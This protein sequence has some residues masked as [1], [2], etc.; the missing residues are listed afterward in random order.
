M[1]IFVLSAACLLVLL[2]Y[3]S[4]K[5]LHKSSITT[6]LDKVSQDGRVTG[7]VHYHGYGQPFVYLETVN[8]REHIT[9]QPNPSDVR[10]VRQAAE[11]MMADYNSSG[12]RWRLGVLLLD[13]VIFLAISIG[14]GW[15]LSALLHWLVFPGVLS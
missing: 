3:L 10:E 1:K 9:G 4:L 12:R 2:L 15:I 5:N 14:F 7:R 11:Q 6:A 13:F 8:Y